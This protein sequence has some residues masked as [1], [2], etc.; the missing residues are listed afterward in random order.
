MPGIGCAPGVG[1]PD[2]TGDPVRPV[3]V[4][5]VPAE[6]REGQIDVLGRREVDLDAGA[7]RLALG[8]VGLEA[9][10][11]LALG[12]PLGLVVGA[13]EAQPVL[14][15]E[16]RGEREAVV[17]A[18]RPPRGWSARAWRTRTCAFQRERAD[19]VA[20]GRGEPRG[21]VVVDVGRG[22]TVRIRRA[23]RDDG[24]AAVRRCSH[25]TGD[26]E[27]VRLVGQVVAAELRA[28]G[29]VLDR[30]RRERQVDR[31]GVDL[32]VERGLL[33]RRQAV[34]PDPGRRQDRRVDRV[35][36]EG[37]VLRPSR[38]AR[39]RRRCGSAGRT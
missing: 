26:D 11:R 35:R 7:L 22:V 34:G 9:V 15:V 16:Q 14:G 27:T 19:V 31:R 6:V 32:A 29:E 24:P 12:R 28:K 33:E 23:G 30:P 36:V 10:E 4:L 38:P 5:D 21:L 18:R 17:V 39:G 2:V 25:V 37:R 13:A 3:R 8:L 1:T 20:G